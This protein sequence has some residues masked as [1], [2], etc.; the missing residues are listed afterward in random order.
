MIF[1]EVRTGARQELGKVWDEG[2]RGKKQDGKNPLEMGMEM[3]AGRSLS[4]Q[5]C[6]QTGS[7]WSK[8]MDFM[9]LDGGEQREH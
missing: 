7:A 3:K 5:C 2:E 9:A 4:Q 6:G 1:L 8:R